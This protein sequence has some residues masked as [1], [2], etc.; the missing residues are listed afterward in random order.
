MPDSNRQRS[1]SSRLFID[2]NAA[3]LNMVQHHADPARADGGAVAVAEETAVEKERTYLEIEL[4]GVN[5]TELISL[6]AALPVSEYGKKPGFKIATDP[7]GNMTVNAYF[8]SPARAKA[9]LTSAITILNQ[10]HNKPI[11]EEFKA[12]SEEL[13]VSVQE[14]HSETVAPRQKGI[15]TEIY[16]DKHAASLNAVTVHTDEV[17]AAYHGSAIAS[18][19]ASMREQTFLQVRLEG[20]S[21][22][23]LTKLLPMLPVSD[24]AP[25]PGFNIETCDHGHLII[26]AYCGSVDRARSLV[27]SAINVLHMPNSTRISEQLRSTGQD[28]VA[29]RG[30]SLS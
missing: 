24:K 15:S 5:K 30:A 18:E 23:E 2:A 9:L 20:V 14:A 25:R 26:T 10:T 11:L 16:I 19:A 22:P 8:D 4:K 7:Q 13:P 27:T 3:S 12:A 17:D 28:F 29:A 1:I 6:L 21:K